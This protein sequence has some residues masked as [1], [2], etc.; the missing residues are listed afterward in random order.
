MVVNHA[1]WVIVVAVLFVVRRG[2]ARRATSPTTCRRV[3]SRIPQSES[4][5]TAEE[6]LA[7]FP[8]A[9][10]SDFV[11]LVTARGGSVDDAAVTEAGDRAH[12]EAARADPAMIEASSYWTLGN[13]A[14]AEEHATATRR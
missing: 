9:G 2:G 6:L 10:Q 4:V 5:K 3:D 12:R 11:V 7:R 14:A 13:R 8:A 1:R